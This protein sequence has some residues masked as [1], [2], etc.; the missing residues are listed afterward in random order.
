MKRWLLTA[1][2]VTTTGAAVAQPPQPPKPPGYLIIRIKLSD[3]GAIAPGAGLGGPGE[4]GGFGGVGGQGGFPGGPG[5]RPGQQGGPGGFPGLGGPGAPG[6][7]GPSGFPGGPGL[8]GPGF[9]GPNANGPLN[10]ANERSVAVMVPYSRI[11]T[12]ALYKDKLVNAERN[13]TL[14]VVIHPYGS[15]VLYQDGTNVQ[16]KV[17]EITTLEYALTQEYKRWAVQ[18]DRKPAVLLRFIDVALRAGL[19]DTAFTYADTMTKLVA[20]R[21]KKDIPADVANFVA[22]YTEMKPKLGESLP[23]DPAA[24]TWKNHL[25]SGATVSNDAPHYTLVHFGEQNLSSESFARKVELLERNFKS[26]YLWYMLKA[27]RSLPLPDK[28]LI[29]VV[30]KRA[31]DLTALRS[32]VD[33]LDF[34][35]DSFFSQQHNLVVMA[36]ER[37]DDIGRSFFDTARA[38]Y[39]VGGFD[40]NELL[41]G[42]H[43][44]LKPPLR[45]TDIALASTY[46]LVDKM[47]EVETDQA[48]ISSDGTRQLFAAAHLLPKHVILPHWVESGVASLLQHPKG[49]GVV[50]LTGK[51]A[52]LAL[53]LYTGHGSPNYELLREF[54]T[55]YPL[56]DAKDAAAEA[57]YAGI[58]RNT[59]TDKYFEAVKSGVDPDGPTVVAAQPGGAGGLPGGLPGFPGFGPAAP[60]GP[61]PGGPGNRPGGGRG[62]PGA[63][64]EDAQQGPRG[65]PGGPGMPGVPSMPGV[66]GGF[67]GPGGGFDGSG[68]GI[69][70]PNLEKPGL[71]KERLEMKAR[72]TSWALTYYLTQKQLPK[73][74]QFYTELDA[75]PRDMRIEKTVVL[76]TFCNVF[77]LMNAD[78]TGIDEVAFKTFARDWVKYIQDLQPSWREIALAALGGNNNANQPGQLGAPGF[79]GGFGG[80]GGAGGPGGGGGSGDGGDR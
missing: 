47:L 67:Q 44:P 45:P 48:S 35:G 29:V 21:D 50:E 24:Q 18:A 1:G 62:G 4:E 19:T 55:F 71:S 12:R 15:T 32:R 69:L 27:G 79:P 58:L 6:L 51:K 76:N 56:K 54:Q 38:K 70:D 20:E 43:P 11:G 31:A 30:A 41:K 10:L 5:G 64:G 78:K 23:I 26:F 60:G 49:S 25:G 17:D 66:P 33:G 9:G 7:G 77:G 36:P 68:S 42:N 73:L 80:L 46:A 65:M 63:P 28:K 57:R 22:A 39:T 59:L 3:S 52:G 40:R 75:L 53:G 37:S 13:P 72:A 14:P 16:M 2:L 61:M 34:V 8:G 74:T